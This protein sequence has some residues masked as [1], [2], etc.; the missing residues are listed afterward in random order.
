MS[1]ALVVARKELRTLFHSPVAL[2]FLAVFELVTLFTFFQ[3]SRWFA[4]NIAD[5]RPLFQWLPLLLVF[6]TAAVT[7]R[8]WAEERKVGTLEVL[9]T[10]P[11]RTWDLVLGKFLAATGLV[12]LALSLTLPL[13][14]MVSVLG[15]LDWGPVVGGY[16]GALLL[17]A[18]YVSIGLCVSART[19]NQVV[20]LMVTLLVGGALYLVGSPTVTALLENRWTEILSA[21]GTGSRFTSIERGVLDVRD[22]AYYAALTATF[23]AVNVASLDADRLD[24]DSPRGRAEQGRLSTWVLQIGRAHV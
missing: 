21:I 4:R 18:L 2:I 17:G 15:P 12:A 9:L 3:G 7:M 16:V 10:L 6:L 23:L 24:V 13:P 1:S 19:D 22:L 20:S 11:V 5:V 14:L 8:Q